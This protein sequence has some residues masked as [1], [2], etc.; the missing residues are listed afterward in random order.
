MK[1]NTIKKN[2]ISHTIKH[3]KFR[4]R[5]Q[6]IKEKKDINQSK[7]VIGFKIKNP[8]FFEINYASIIYSYILGGSADSLLFKNVREK[9]S[10][11]YYISSNIY[12]VS[13][14]MI[15]NSGIKAKDASKVIRLVKKQIKNMALGIF[16]DKYIENGKEM[17]IS[18]CNEVYDSPNDLLNVYISNEYLQNGLVEDKKKEIMKVTKN[19]IMK[20]ASKLY[21]DTI[22][23]LEGDDTDESK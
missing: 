14:I 13:N 4:K 23:I 6:I 11:C 9:H 18:A 8:S 10:L 12:K 22:Y 16:D 19:D 20:F 15:I 5:A 1:I 17:F 21:L 2:G 3:D 7:L